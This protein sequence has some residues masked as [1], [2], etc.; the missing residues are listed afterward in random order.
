MMRSGG[1]LR[2]QYGAAFGAHCVWYFADDQVPQN[3]E[4]A[5]VN[6]FYTT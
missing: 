2:Y 1:G 5:L 3:I 6:S 4:V